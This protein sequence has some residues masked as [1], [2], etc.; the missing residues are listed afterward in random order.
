M[1]VGFPSYGNDAAASTQSTG[2]P[3]V[4]GNREWPMSI[5]EAAASLRDEEPKNW[6]RTLRVGIFESMAVA[7]PPKLVN[8]PSKTTMFPNG[9][10]G[11]SHSRRDVVTETRE[12]LSGKEYDCS[13]RDGSNRR[14]TRLPPC[15]HPLLVS[16]Q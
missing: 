16:C 11:Q 4:V 1:P 6:P 9:K 8:D 10:I 14:E 2:M 5:V 15:R 12:R 3:C 13:D 7:I